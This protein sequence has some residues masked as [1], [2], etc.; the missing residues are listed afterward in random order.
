[1]D[2]LSGPSALD[3]VKIVELGSVLA[4]PLAGTLLADFGADVIHIEKPGKGD[5]MR[6]AGPPTTDGV[7]VWWKV[8]MRNKR[9]VTLDISK[10]A[11]HSVFSRLIEWADVVTENFRPGVLESWGLGPEKLLEINPNL[12]LLRISGFGQTGPLRN[13]PGFGKVG[14][15]MSGIVTLT[16]FPDNPPTHVGFSLGDTTTGL[17]GALGVMMAL[18]RRKLTP[19]AT[20][21]IIDLALFE[22]LFRLLEW[23]VPAYDKIGFVGSR[24]GNRFPFGPAIVANAYV[25]SDGFWVTISTATQDYVDLCVQML[26]SEADEYRAHAGEPN[27]AD[28]LDDAISRW[29]KQRG[30]DEALEQ[31]ARASVV[32]SMIYNVEDILA[33]ETYR[34]RG[35]IISV[36]DSDFGDLRQPAPIPH[37]KNLPGKVWREAP[38]LG[39]DNDYVYRQL[40]GLDDRVIAGMMAQHL[41]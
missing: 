10:P 22:T 37:F 18:Y 12:V 16:G 27:A 39:A 21:E 8:T 32:A 36:P 7:H 31:L 13:R 38:R 9:S 14:E 23:Q 4:G 41:I 11:S 30:K 5:P 29:M 35:D 20:G 3:G 6:V 28:I 24:T 17:M 1:M 34:I 25:T 40:L 26:G 33:D 2:Q 15:A 19:S